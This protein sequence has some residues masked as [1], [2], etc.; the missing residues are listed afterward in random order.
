M[1]ASQQGLDGR[2]AWVTG[3]G[4]G[5]GRATAEWLARR[6]DRYRPGYHV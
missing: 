5:I 2:L 6:L 4:T 3:G 1:S